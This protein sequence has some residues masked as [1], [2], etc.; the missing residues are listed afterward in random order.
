MLF[1]ED[2][3]STD[4]AL[5]ST[6]GAVLLGGGL[7]TPHLAYQFGDEILHLCSSHRETAVPPAVLLAAFIPAL[8]AFLVWIQAEIE[9]QLTSWEVRWLTAGAQLGFAPFEAPSVSQRCT[10]NA[11]WGSSEAVQVPEILMGY[12][13]HKPV[14]NVL[15]GVFKC[16]RTHRVSA[17]PLFLWH[18]SALICWS[19]TTFCWTDFRLCWPMTKC[20]SWGMLTVSQPTWVPSLA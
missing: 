11:A 5:L 6:Y 16:H 14:L 9:P 1:K 13:V 12:C 10:S 4:L 18:I 15:R 19:T 20:C 8:T 17:S 7:V 3:R 2:L